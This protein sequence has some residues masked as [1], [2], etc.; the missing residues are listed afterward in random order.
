MIPM[1]DG[2]GGQL[3]PL[4]SD[5]GMVLATVKEEASAVA[6]EFPATLGS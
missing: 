1:G 4:C 2:S 3:E 6:P 5:S